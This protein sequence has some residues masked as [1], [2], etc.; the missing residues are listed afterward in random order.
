METATMSNKKTYTR[1]GFKK[2]ETDHIVEQLN[3]VLANY[4]VHYQKLRNFHWNVVG[5]DFFDL[6]ENFE[7]YYTE[8]I[9]NI[10]VLAERIRVFGQT[11]LSTMVDYLRVSE[12]KEVGTD[13]KSDQMAKEIVNDF[14][15]LVK[16]LDNAASIASEE[17]DVGTEDMIIAFIREIEKN[18]WMLNSFIK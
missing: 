5:S 8:A 12:I 3:I 2:S 13:F 17:G 15:I 18:H 9:E 11:P 14:E 16:H 6:H 7:K 10:D 1:L 4:H